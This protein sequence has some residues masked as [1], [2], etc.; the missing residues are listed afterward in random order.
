MLY[1]SLCE[2]PIRDWLLSFEDRKYLIKDDATHTIDE[3]NECYYK[4][5]EEKIKY[6]GVDSGLDDAISN[7]AEMCELYINHIIEGKDYPEFKYYELEAKMKESSTKKQMNEGQ[8]LTY[9]Y[10]NYKEMLN[11]I[12]NTAYD[13]LIILKSNKK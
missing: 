11:P 2:I 9:I 12:K 7:I 4:L 6:F 1:N 5:L 10:N 8:L 3:V 13:L